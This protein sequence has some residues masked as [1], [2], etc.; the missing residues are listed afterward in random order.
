[1]TVHLDKSTLYTTAVT[2]ESPEFKKMT[3]KE[4]LMHYDGQYTHS[5]VYLFNPTSAETQ[6][7]G[8]V[9]ENITYLNAT[10]YQ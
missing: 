3:I 9:L 4:T 5:C 2:Y 10:Y 8:Y 6:E 7:T 1:M